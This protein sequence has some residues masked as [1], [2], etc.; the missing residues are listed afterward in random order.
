MIFLSPS[1]PAAPWADGGRNKPPEA[2]KWYPERCCQHFHQS[3]GEQVCWQLFGALVCFWASPEELFW[4]DSFVSKSLAVSE[5]VVKLGTQIFWAGRVAGG[6]CIESGLSEQ[7]MTF[8]QLEAWA[9][10]LWC[11][12]FKRKKCSSAQAPLVFL[13]GCLFFPWGW[14]WPLG[15]TAALNFRYQHPAVTGTAGVALGFICWWCRCLEKQKCS[16]VSY[17]L[18]WQRGFCALCR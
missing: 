18:G 10:R 8:F 13:A 7:I 17:D 5:L 2:G 6:V 4:L 16:F 9:F 1:V 11:W 3:N 12:G 14:L 15:R